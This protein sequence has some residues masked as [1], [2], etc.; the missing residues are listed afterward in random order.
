[1]A[2]EI[3]LTQEE[4]EENCLLESGIINAM[5]WHDGQLRK[6]TNLPYIVHPLEV[7]NIL[8]QMG[9][10]KK[11]MIAGVLHDTVEDTEATLE[12]IEEIFGKD[13]ADLVASHTEMD[14]SL[15]WRERKE[16]A[17]EHLA[18]ASKRE[19][20]LVLADKLSNIEAMARDFDNVG[21][22]LW[23]RFN[24]GRDEQEWYY[25]EAVKAMSKL[26]EEPDV[27]QYYHRFVG[28]VDYVFDQ[29]NNAYYFYQQLEKLFDEN[30]AEHALRQ[31]D[32][33]AKC[34][35]VGA[36][37]ALAEAYQGT[38]TIEANL[39]E[40]FNWW[41]LAAKTGNPIAQYNFGKCFEN[42]KGVEVDARQALGWYLKAAEQGCVEAMN[43]IGIYYA[44]G[45]EVEKS[46]EEAFFWFK[47]ACENESDVG[48]LYNLAKCYEIGF[49]TEVDLVE[50]KRL[51][52]LADELLA[53]DQEDNDW[54]I[55]GEPEN[56]EENYN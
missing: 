55:V 5:L 36:M 51:E 25:R 10:D 26:G 32:T 22:A 1:M 16:I 18:K 45:I 34:G 21:D 47:K 13:V 46:A 56:L 48:A 37:I 19:Q 4:L 52:K 38:P 28:A 23:D 27:M 17:L 8:L 11:L 41:K 44:Q 35:H 9:A 14:K 7:M 20:M 6:G 29:Q 24:K 3:I 49:G 54:K 39:E 12:D 2:K 40:S 15:P 30:Q 50:A 43:D 53:E 42:G 33:M 31:L